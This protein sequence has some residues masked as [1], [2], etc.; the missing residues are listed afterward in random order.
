MKTMA[1]QG[2]RLAVAAIV[3]W[4]VM[5]GVGATS[6]SVVPPSDPW[7]PG[8]SPFPVTLESDPISGRWDVLGFAD[9]A[10]TPVALHFDGVPG[11]SKGDRLLVRGVAAGRPAVIRGR[12]V[13]GTIDVTAILDRSEP[14]DPLLRSANRL[15]ARL[16]TT[17][18][19]GRSD[20]RALLV[21]FLIGDTTQVDPVVL[22]DLRRSGLS[23][24]VAVSGSNVALFL[25]LW[26]IITTPLSMSPR[27][28][29]AVGAIGLIVFGHL[30]RWEPSV[31]RA[32]A[33]AL[34]ALVGRTV[35]LVLDAWSALSIAVIG[36]LLAS[37]GLALSLG[38][39]LS[40]A[41][42]VGILMVPPITSTALRALAM[43]AGAQLAVTPILLASFGQVPLFSPLA[44]L[45]A[46]PVVGVATV[47]GGLGG[48]VGM[49]RLIGVAVAA[50]DVVIAIGRV[51][52]SLPQVGWLAIG[53]VAVG[54]AVVAFRPG[55]RPIGWAAASLVLAISV[56]PAGRA[57]QTPAVVFLDVGQG[58]SALVLGS[59]LV[60]L[61]DGGPDPAR[62]EN[63]LRRYRVD[64][65]DLVVATHVHA[66]HL[67]G[68][69]SLVERHP[70]GELWQAFD[71]HS[72]EASDRLLEAAGRAGVPV[73]RPAIGTGLHSKDVGV[74]VVGP[75]RRY[76]SPNDQSVVLVIELDGTRV[77]F[78]GDAE[79][80]AQ[81][82]LSIQGVDVL[83]VPHQGA[84]TSDLEWLAA[85][86]GRLAVI[87]VGPNDYGHPSESVIEALEIAGARVVQTDLWGDVVVTPG[88]VV[89]DASR[90]RRSEHARAATR[91][92]P[93]RRARLCGSC[94]PARRTPRSCGRATRRPL[95]PPPAPCREESPPRSIGRV[96]GGGRGRP[97]PAPTH[98]A[99]CR[100]PGGVDSAG[101]SLSAEG[102]RRRQS[103]TRWHDAPPGPAPGRRP[104]R[105]T[106]HSPAGCRRRRCRTA[107]A[108]RSPPPVPL[109]PSHRSPRTPR[110][111]S[112]VP[113]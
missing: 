33:M 8:P 106:G 104:A 45:V 65:V 15:R 20:G 99:L 25:G 76:A 44:N 112:P 91:R 37:P 1:G 22:E 64:H 72:T 81:A 111:R 57:V 97:L 17:I 18:E 13:A 27:W 108:C 50:S 46:I 84:A 49:D 75:V 6:P 68:L 113:G 71:P 42:T 56:F 78:P 61:I 31:I 16:L 12:A 96:R 85:H 89:R 105:K 23:H 10:G 35:G 26:W 67:T 41:A 82:E 98:R 92:C 38:F 7:V 87:S 48:L 28:R 4:L 102:N 21:G 83:K 36:S 14:S 34:V 3:V 94:R 60:I 79:T 39:Q 100:F 59:D 55:R 52:S 40:V 74:S 107:R 95:P 32:S 19:P 101:G 54:L 47:V 93:R 66:D 69:I 43:T 88:P 9:A 90:R 70:V 109:P 11:V 29:A 63:A 53:A 73:R 58:D 110:T 30:T 5:A 103:R 24:L 80:F 51:G 77:L 2:R 86:A 62:L